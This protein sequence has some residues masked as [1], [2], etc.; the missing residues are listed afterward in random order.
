MAVSPV[1][2][3]KTPQ[4]VDDL[5]A[6]EQTGLTEDTLGL[7]LLNVMANDLGGAAK[8]L[9]SVDDGTGAT[10]LL[11]RDGARTEAASLDRSL[12]GATLWIT[13]D[14][15]VGYDAS[16][17]SAAF[18]ARLQQLAAGETLEDS[19]TY[20]I[21]MGNGTIST[22]TAV[23]RIAGLND[24]PV[25]TSAAQA[26]EVKEDTQLSAA[27]Q[28][29]ASDVDHGDH[30][31]YALL[32]SGSGTYGSLGVDA[33]SGAWT[34]TLDNGSGPVQGLRGNESHDEWFTV[35]V[36]DDYGAF[37]DQ[38]VKITIVGTNDLA[39][40]SGDSTGTLGEDDAAPVSGT[41]VIADIDTGEAHSVAA[42]GSSGLGAW[43]VDAD[44]NWSYA[45]DN[46]AVQHLAA[47]TTTSD[48]FTVSSLD[49]TAHQLVS[50]TING[51]NDGAS[52]SGAASGSIGEDAASAVTGALVV[53]DIDDGEAHS[54]AASGTT[55][56]G[57]WSVDADG[58]WSYSVNNA[59][60]QFL[61]DGQ[62]ASDSFVVSS[63]D[64]SST[65]TV[66]ITILGSTDNHPPAITSGGT[67][68]EAENAAASNVVYQATATD[69][70]GDTLAWSLGGADAA[71]FSISA[72][73]AVTFKASP[74]FESP[75]DAGGNNVYDIT[76]TATD[77]LGASASR[78]VA[79]SVTNAIEAPV[80]G[81]DLDFLQS[82]TSLSVTIN[83]VTQSFAGFFG[84][85]HSGTNTFALGDGQVATFSGNSFSFAANSFFHGYAL[86]SYTVDQDLS[87]GSG[88]DIVAS[89][90]SGQAGDGGS[91]NDILFGNGGN[92][93]L[94]GS[95]GND[96]ILGGAGDD[97]LNGANSND[98][99]V[100]GA[101]NDR[102][103]GDV[104]ND[105]F[106]FL[107]TADGVDTITDFVANNDALDLRDLLSGYVAGSSAI[108]DFVKLTV[109]G[110][111][112]TVSVD[113]NG[114]VAPN[115]FTDIAVLQGATGLSL[116]TML[117]DGSLIVV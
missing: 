9:Y 14:G 34:Y 94:T 5:F 76:V 29:T 37:A 18:K 32:G 62:T 75:L 98:V 85:G 70:D 89:S 58:H 108:G 61:N 96:L 69:A 107:S 86:G 42:S 36:T 40:I 110:G 60:V 84:S 116:S 6:A 87:G 45:V 17:L 56:L 92:D 67:G 93:T 109:A 4:A 72:G 19:F 115:S 117:A 103:T 3:S 95:Q 30:Q 26:G 68:S 55:S 25:I 24:A 39:H 63:L 77:P 28:V 57:S 81:N 80:I 22:A 35:R 66:D 16:T 99:L 83:G 11:A 27:G 106:V 2:F 54:V 73:G 51:L 15:R 41:L 88:A 20:A 31:H 49:G 90:N 23:V 97:T 112:T 59:A 82:G 43:S 104:G 65:R 44:G 100:G 114:S 46:D 71:R 113:A 13:A 50:I 10:D 91:G 64:G 48:S 1:S 111:N 21:Q 74:N 38:A 78:A 12:N 53:A 7:A 102:L 33:A 52:I 105:R 8:S 47:N 79:I 101:G